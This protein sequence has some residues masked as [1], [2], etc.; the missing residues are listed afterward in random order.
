MIWDMLLN[1]LLLMFFFVS[2]LNVIRNG[3]YFIQ[4]WVKSNSENPTKY[5]LSDKSLLM[6]AISLS[7][8]L[9]SLTTGIFI[10]I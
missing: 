5:I 2:L 7:Y 10:K 8:V 3:Y 6:L 1:K 9:M 4:A